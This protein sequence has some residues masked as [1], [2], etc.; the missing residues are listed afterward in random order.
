MAARRWLEVGKEAPQTRQNSGNVRR[1]RMVAASWIV[2]VREKR[3]C[4]W[5]QIVVVCMLFGGAATTDD[6]IV[7]DD[8]KVVVVFVQRIFGEEKQC[9]IREFGNLNRVYMASV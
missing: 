2:D 3:E 1:S 7:V 6:D 5:Q 8:G 9:T 4:Y